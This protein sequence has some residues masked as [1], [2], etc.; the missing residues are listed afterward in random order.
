M[1]NKKVLVSIYITEEL[2]AAL[3]EAAKKENRN[4]SNY[5]ET[6]LKEVKQ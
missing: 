4:L 6:K 5:I 1:E 2:K 3:E